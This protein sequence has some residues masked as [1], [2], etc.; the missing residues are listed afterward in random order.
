MK[1]SDLLACCGSQAWA[2]EMASHS[3]PNPKEVLATADS[4]WWSLDPADWQE[5][6]RANTRIADRAHQTLPHASEAAVAE[7]RNLQRTY[8]ERFG[9]LYVV[10][11][12]GRSAHSVIENLR[13]RIEHDLDTE[14]RTAAQQQLDITH[15]R[16][17]RLLGVN[18]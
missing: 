12:N 7:L 18:T 14:I 17:K 16:L 5:A 11:V 13:T 4:V 1:E 6:F 10:F 15:F 3:F 8:E 9:Y 2:K